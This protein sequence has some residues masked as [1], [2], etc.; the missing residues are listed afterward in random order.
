[1]KILTAI[2]HSLEGRGHRN[3]VPVQC[4]CGVSFLWN[5]DNGEVV[6][7]PTCGTLDKLG[8]LPQAATV[9]SLDDANHEGGG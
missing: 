8:W 1:M 9:G 6:K 2:P 7:C 3:C 4:D 5:K